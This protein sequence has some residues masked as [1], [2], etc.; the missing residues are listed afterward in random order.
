MLRAIAAAKNK[1]YQI[2]VSKRFANHASGA[3]G[4]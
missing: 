3:A 2:D 1:N 4:L